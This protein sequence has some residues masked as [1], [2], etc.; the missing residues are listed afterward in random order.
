MW[1]ALD[2]SD[3]TLSNAAKSRSGLTFVVGTKHRVQNPRHV[4]KPKSIASTHARI[5][6]V[7]TVNFTSLRTRVEFLRACV[8]EQSV[9]D[10]HT[11]PRQFK[12]LT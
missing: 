9:A 2:F 8:N 4:T 5:C 6:R 3:N 10:L 11:K 7:Y 12:P 1:V